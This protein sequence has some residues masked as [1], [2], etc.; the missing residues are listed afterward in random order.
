MEVSGA[1]SFVL[2]ET[3]AYTTVVEVPANT[4]F[5]SATLLAV[6]KWTRSSAGEAWKLELHQTIPWSPETKAQGTLR[7]DSRGCVALTRGPERRTSG[8]VIG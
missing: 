3:E 7:C 8:G 6:Q 5:D 1:D 4:G 2:S